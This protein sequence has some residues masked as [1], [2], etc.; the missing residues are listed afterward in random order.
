MSG[1]DGRPGGDAQRQPRQ[2][3]YPVV[4]PAPEGHA[5]RVCAQKDGRD[6]RKLHLVHPELPDHSHR[7]GCKSLIQLDQLNIVQA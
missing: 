1:G 5:D 6:L 4:Q 7:L 2:Q 3:P